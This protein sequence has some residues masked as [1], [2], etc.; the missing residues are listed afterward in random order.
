MKLRYDDKQEYSTLR[1]SFPL[2]LSVMKDNISESV[3][4]G[5]KST[6]VLCSL[7][8]PIGGW[9]IPSRNTRLYTE[10]LYDLVFQSD[11]VKELFDTLN[12][13]GE[14]D[15]PFTW[16][17]RA[18]IHYPYV[19]HAVRKVWKDK[20]NGCWMCIVDILDTPNGRIIKTLVDYGTKI[21]ISS[22]GAGDLVKRDG[23][24]Y[25]D[26][27][28][29]V[30]FTLDLVPVPGHKIARLSEV[31]STDLA[32]SINEV[33]QSSNKNDTNLTESLNYTLS[34]FLK[35]SIDDE[36]YSRLRTALG[37]ADEA[38]AKSNDLVRVSELLEAYKLIDSLSKENDELKSKLENVPNG[39]ISIDEYELLDEDNKKLKSKLIELSN[40]NMDARSRY[41]KLESELSDANS[42]IEQL[43]VQLS[44]SESKYSD[45]MR[46]YI[47]LKASSLGI[48]KYYIDSKI[49]NLLE[50]SKSQVDNELRKAVRSSISTSMTPMSS[51]SDD[52]IVPNGSSV[53][54]TES[55]RR[56]YRSNTETKA[57]GDLSSVIASLKIR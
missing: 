11:Y 4:L 48:D 2:P 51:D 49:D 52:Y 34:N 25:V 17:D 50:L 3:N 47:N 24:V 55:S 44:N 5:N 7:I 1:D 6:A 9:I 53:S 15:H 21:G 14:P 10:R 35:E 40:D 46:G 16:E 20:S 30:F 42:S 29:Y 37:I 27:D 56:R 31:E 26:E 39:E 33:I 54:L 41:S 32:N 12:F 23:K 57:D 36:A 45:L 13:L 8:G 43:K 38:N 18:D 28:T 22:R 19:S